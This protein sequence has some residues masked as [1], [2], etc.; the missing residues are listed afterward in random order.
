MNFIVIL[1]F[2]SAPVQKQS[3]G[4][5]GLGGI[6]RQGFG[7]APQ[8]QPVSTFPMENVYEVAMADPEDEEEVKVVRQPRVCIQCTPSIHCMQ[9]LQR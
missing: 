1:L 3:K 6:A 5:V 8:Q 7:E 9:H 2:F 4:R